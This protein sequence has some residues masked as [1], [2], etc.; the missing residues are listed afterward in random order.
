ML[1]LKH[2]GQSSCLFLSLFKL[3]LTRLVCLVLAVVFIGSV[4]LLSACSGSENEYEVFEQPDPVLPT[5]SEAQ[6]RLMSAVNIAGSNLVLTDGKSIFFND[7]NDIFVRA[8]SDGSSP[9]VIVDETVAWPF[10]A[11]EQLYF[12]SGSGF[13]PL[14]KIR[15]DGTNKVRIGQK[16]VSNLIYHND[17]IYAIEMPE[18]TAIRVRP[19]GNGREVIST[20]PVSSMIFHENVLYLASKASTNGLIRYDPETEKS[21]TIANVAAGCIQAENDILYFTDLQRQYQL[22]AL[23]LQANTIDR[24]PIQILNQAI[25]KPFIISEGWLFF[26]D[27]SK[28]QQIFSLKINASEKLNPSDAIITVD[29]AAEKFVVIFPFIYYQRP[30]QNRIYRMVVGNSR[31]EPVS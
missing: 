7:R 31:P 12:V 21:E 20:G 25:E 15:T 29:D 9:E 19:D 6:I 27:S 30:D 14:G 11:D 24:Q 26:I 17:Y 13:G 1:L 28:K 2:S 4:F 16:A 23:E 22:F 18:G 8:N 5:D 3:N 10:V